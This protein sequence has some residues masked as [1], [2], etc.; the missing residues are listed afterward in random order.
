MG[1]WKRIII[2]AIIFLAAAGFFPAGFHVANIWVALVA[3]VVLSVLNM[4]VKPL[5]TVISLPITVLTLGLFS[6]VINAAMLELTAL[7]VGGAFA[8]ANFGWALV[9]ALIISAVN[10]VITNYF[11]D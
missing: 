4:V 3:A 5:L 8:F 11:A 9:V 2:N 6:W 7:V 10:V 1:F